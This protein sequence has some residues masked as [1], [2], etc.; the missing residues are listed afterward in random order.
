[1]ERAFYVWKSHILAQQ[2]FEFACLEKTKEILADELEQAMLINET[3]TNQ[4][5]LNEL[6]HY[7][8][9]NCITR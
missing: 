8:C 1:M 2:K 5:Q 7:K 3:L 9:A 6:K 4:S